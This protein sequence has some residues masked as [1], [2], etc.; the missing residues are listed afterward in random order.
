MSERKKIVLLG[1]TGSIGENTLKVIRGHSDKLEL[2]G[3]AANS[4]IKNLA[5]IAQEF[6][7]PHVACYDH[8][9]GKEAQNN[10]DF[11]PNTVFHNGLEG[12]TEIACLQEADLVVAAV[13]GTTALKPVLSAIEAGN[14][15]ALANKEIL[16]L[17]GKFVMAAARKHNV[18][19]LPLD[20]EHNAIFQCL[21][22]APK[23]EIKKL[24]LTASGGSFRERALETL[25]Q[26]T[27][28]EALSHP[29]W[30]MGKKITVDCSTMANKGLE[31]IEA[32]W[33]FDVQPE[34]IDV[35]I[36]PQ[37]TVH[38]MVEFID[39][40]IIGQLSPPSMTFAIQHILLYPERYPGVEP[41]LDF[42]QQLSLEFY[43]PDLKRFPC[44]AMARK[45][46]KA[47]GTAPAIYNAANEI[48]V[49]AFLAHK[50]GFL[51]IAATI[52]K[53]LENFTII[54]PSSLDE[55]LQVDLEARK[56]AS[57]FI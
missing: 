10:G 46:L 47:G 27:P 49:S 11:A 3:I 26:V 42:S 20:S 51:E 9:A 43:Q 48:A 21:N 31:V 38:S 4:N 45:A 39:G 2:I 1:A 50:I 17:A 54:E 55:V 15:I 7:V 29:N 14:N 35:V 12:L 56:M 6:N 24:I 52:D 18:N 19:I 40:S 22:G 13:V 57:S 28:E 37:S 30:N 53:T 23:K 41:T 34:Q 36:H 16:V 25:S 33:L 8:Q 44:F 32:H 5:K